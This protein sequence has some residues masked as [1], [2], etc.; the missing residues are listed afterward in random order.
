ML[1]IKE[2]CQSLVDATIEQ[3]G[4]LDIAVNNAGACHE[5]KKFIDLDSK[6]IDFMLD[7]NTKGVFYGMS[8]QLK[9]MVKQ[10]DGVILNVSSMAG[11]SGS[12]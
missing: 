3:Y 12:R 2:Q 5:L 7:L 10:K 9:Q 1:P 4:R 11:I 8:A 6:E